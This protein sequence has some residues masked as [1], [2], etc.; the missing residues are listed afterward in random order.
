MYYAEGAIFC[1]LNA[2]TKNSIE[3]YVAPEVAPFYK[4]R[5]RAVPYND[6]TLWGSRSKM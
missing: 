1:Q 4:G 5:V 6:V 2:I 3:C